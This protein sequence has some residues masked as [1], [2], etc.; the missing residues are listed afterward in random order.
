[1][2]TR[3]SCDAR[4]QRNLMKDTDVWR[5]PSRKKKKEK[6]NIP[7]RA[8]NGKNRRVRLEFLWEDGQ[9]AI[10]G[11]VVPQKK[12]KKKNEEGEKNGGLPL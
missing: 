9:D 11:V 5:R 3:C 10:E 12:N 7:L 4:R 6:K 8:C 2:R 1:M